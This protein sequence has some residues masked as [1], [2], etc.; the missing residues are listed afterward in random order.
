MNIVK[1]LFKH[2]NSVSNIYSVNLDKLLKL[3]ES[4]DK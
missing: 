2:Y 3:L 4:E 1:F